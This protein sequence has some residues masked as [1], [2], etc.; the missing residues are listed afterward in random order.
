MICP[1]CSKTIAE[2]DTYL[3]SR[4]LPKDAPLPDW[5]RTMGLIGA[6]IVV[7]L[8]AAFLYHTLGLPRL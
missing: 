6:C 4:R 8:L 2:Q 5:A 1:H 7:A 3:M